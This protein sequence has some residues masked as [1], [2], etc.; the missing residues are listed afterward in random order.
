MVSHVCQPLQKLQTKTGRPFCMNTMDGVV[1]TSTFFTYQHALQPI[2]A[3]SF[4]PAGFPCKFSGR[5]ASRLLLFNR[6]AICHERIAPRLFGRQLRRSSSIVNRSLSTNPNFSPCSSPA[7]F[8]CS[9]VR[10]QG[11]TSMFSIFFKMWHFC[12]LYIFQKLGFLE[13]IPNTNEP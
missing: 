10:C 7:L 3:F 8:C 9:L 5:H 4:L 1:N 6:P 2:W 11:I 13:M 12:I